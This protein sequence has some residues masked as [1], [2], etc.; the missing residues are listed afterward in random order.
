MDG[1][2]DKKSDDKWLRITFSN[3]REEVVESHDNSCPESI[4][5]INEVNC[6]SL[7]DLPL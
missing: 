2:T 1:K 4:W 3:K 6:F 5:H 7:S